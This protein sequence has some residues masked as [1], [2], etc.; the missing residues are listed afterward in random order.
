MFL[1]AAEQGEAETL[2]AGCKFEAIRLQCLA[3]ARPNRSGLA[4]FVKRQEISCTLSSQ[5]KFL[6]AAIF[7]FSDSMVDQ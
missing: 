7:I 1:Q 3:G 6:P 2:S 4:C 5:S